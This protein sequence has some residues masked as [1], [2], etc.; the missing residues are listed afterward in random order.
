MGRKIELIK[1][2]N[3]FEEQIAEVD[4]EDVKSLAKLALELTPDA[5]VTEILGHVSALGEYFRQNQE[6]QL[7]DVYKTIVASQYGNQLLCE[8]TQ[9]TAILQEEHPSRI[10]YD[11]CVENYSKILE[12]NRMMV[13][14]KRQELES[15]KKSDK[16]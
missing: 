4:L 16:R 13:E 11:R 14:R 5:E 1:H 12:A 2:V 3:A 15:I 10:R 8:T 7:I 6:H 9:I